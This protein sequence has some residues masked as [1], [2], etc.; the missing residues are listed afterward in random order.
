MENTS[1]QIGSTFAGTPMTTSNMADQARIDAKA[2]S[3]LTI[4]KR[5]GTMVPFRR[6]RIQNA[7]ELAMRATH[8]IPSTAPLTPD[9]FAQL[10]EV[11]DQVILGSLEKAKLGACLTVE[12]IQD[13]VEVK[14]ME[15]GHHDVARDYIVYRDQHKQLRDDSPRN[16]RVMR[17]DGKEV[18]FNPMKIASAIEACFRSTRSVDGVTPSEVIQA[19]NL[20]TNKVVNKVCDYNNAGKEISV[21]FIQDEV[22]RQLMS[23]SFYQ[24]AK[25]YILYRSL[26]A[27]LRENGEGSEEDAT[28]VL[29]KAEQKSTPAAKTAPTENLGTIYTVTEADGSQTEMSELEIKKRIDYAC[30]NLNVDSDEVR[31]DML[32]NFY[33]GIRRKEVDQAAIMSARAKVEKEPDYT[34]LTARL[35]LDEIY[36]E[37]ISTPANHA[38]IKKIHQEYFTQYIDFGVQVGRLT[39]DLKTYDIAKLAAA[40]DLSRDLDFTYLGLQTIYDRYLTHHED[41]RIE[42]PQIFWMRVAMGLALREGEHKNARAIEFY[43]ILS[44]MY[45]VSSTP[46]LFNSGTCHSQMSSCYLSTVT[47]D[48]H[49]IFKLVSDDAQLSKWAG[50][51]G[52]DWTNVRATGATIKGTN[53][54]SQG[55]VPFLK[56]ANDTAVAVNQG[57]KRKGAMCAYLETWHLDL[58]DFLELR[59]NTGDERRRTH[60]M[61]TANW[62]PDLFMKRVAEN[63]NWT[64]FSP[65]DVP[66]LHDLYGAAFDKR[67]QE[68]E[69]MVAKGEI[70]LYK[71]VEAL[72]LWRKMLSMLFETGHPWITFKDP[73]NLRSPQDHKGVVHSSN[74]CTE[75]LLNT[76]EKETAVCN[77]GSLNLPKH[78]KANGDLDRELLAKNIK[79]AIRMLDNVI[80]INFYPIPEAEFSNLQHRPIGLGIMGFQD[81]LYMK[82]VS[83]ASPEAVEF[84]DRSMELISYYAILGSSEL[85]KERG[86]YPSY[87]GSKWDRGLLPIDT[88]EILEKN[89][90]AEYCDLNKETTLDWQVVRD[91]I[92]KYGMRNSNT[93]AIA[94]TATISNIS[95]VTQSIEPA[96]KHL[97][98]KSNLSGEFIVINDYLVHELKKLDLWDEEMVDDLK[99]FDGS[100]LE[101]ER[102]PN[103]LKQVYLTS[104]EIDPEWIVDCAARRQKWIDMGQSLN[105]YMAEPSGK[106]LNEMYFSAWKKGLKTTYYLRCL[107]ATQIE[108]STMDVNKRGLQPRWMKNKSSSGEVNVNRDAVA[109]PKETQNLD[110]ECE[111][112]Q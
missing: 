65:S 81:C 64:M 19:V 79:T 101:I 100:I 27:K 52:N 21:E 71:T 18:R 6:E 37:T 43:D 69:E 41:R 70:K 13:I 1:T 54:R 76:S 39:A 91:S 30:L 50:G 5:N 90:G 60:D 53:G 25:N 61:N 45:Y 58:E 9:L 40:M 48:L 47:D 96:Y 44:K 32:K 109:L 66:D 78:I 31:V 38:D 111:S 89:R 74:L 72:T 107:G 55:V 46:T 73:S 10:Q 57:G 12:G 15:C 95:G 75:I 98:A 4:V 63:G 67:Y 104:F 85:A 88:L 83:Y 97:F 77:L 99:Y 28:P 59:K 49:S 84:A 22:E 87:Q 86:A 62:I 26:R 42:T 24:E 56:V 108:K 51:L 68:Y 2:L 23:E 17:R 36:R 110:G 8:G 106:K 20:L 3:R 93:M 34:F 33:Q 29:A 92:K 94:P 112:C 16:I 82:R 102:I 105:L 14:L 35:L 11:T 7:I 103:D 80:D